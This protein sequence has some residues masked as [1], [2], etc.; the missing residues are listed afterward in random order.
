MP[1]APQ[2]EMDVVVFVSQPLF[3]L[4]SQLPKPIAHIGVHM[5][6]VH[7]VVPFIFEHVVPHV[8]QLDV[9]VPVLISQPLPY[10][11]SQF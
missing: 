11:P 10:I 7:D 3:G 6:L 8:P 2:F 1:H 4:P 5:P 9:L